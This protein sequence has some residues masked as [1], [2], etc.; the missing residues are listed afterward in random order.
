M[1]GSGH[2]HVGAA[3]GLVLGHTAGWPVWQSVAAAVIAAGCARVPDV[4]N[5][6]WWQTADRVIPDEALGHGGPMRHRGVTHWWLWPVAVAVC[7]VVAGGVAGFVLGSVAAGWG[8]HIAA[9]A[10]FGARSRYRGPGVPLFP[11]W[12]HVG[13][14]LKSDGITAQITAPVTLAAVVVWVTGLAGPIATAIGL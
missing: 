10:V 5:R 14:G 13:V 2:I 3:A 11:W 9:D 4:D 6:G 12:G 7:A 8:S 1:N